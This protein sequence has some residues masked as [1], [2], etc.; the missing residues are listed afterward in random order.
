M[1]NKETLYG[2]QRTVRFGLQDYKDYSSKNDAYSNVVK[3]LM[4]N[5]EIKNKINGLLDRYVLSFD[6]E[7]WGKFT[8]QLQEKDLSELWGYLN[9]I[10][11]SLKLLKEIENKSKHQVSLNLRHLKVK[12][13]FGKDLFFLF[14][15]ES[16]TQISAQTIHD[17]E[18][19]K[20][21]KTKLAKH[22][23]F[24]KEAFNAC[25]NIFDVYVLFLKNKISS[26]ED[27]LKR[28]GKYLENSN[29]DRERLAEFHR[30]V[31]IITRDFETLHDHYVSAFKFSGLVYETVK[32]FRDAI[33][34]KEVRPEPIKQLLKQLLEDFKDPNN[35]FEIGR[36]TM[37]Y[38]TLKKQANDSSQVENLKKLLGD[39]TDNKLSKIA[40]KILDK[41]YENKLSIHNGGSLIEKTEKILQICNDVAKEEKLKTEG[42]ITLWD[43]ANCFNNKLQTY[44]QFI[45][46][47]QSFDELGL[48]QRLRF[49]LTVLVDCDVYNGKF[50][51]RCEEIKDQAEKI[52]KIFKFSEYKTYKKHTENIKYQKNAREEAKKRG[53]FFKK[54][55]LYKKTIEI[56]KIIASIKGSLIQYIKFLEDE[57]E[58]IGK[59]QFYAVLGESNGEKII[60]LADK[61][62]AGDFKKYLWSPQNQQGSDTVFLY[63]SITWKSLQKLF[64]QTYSN[65]HPF[66]TSKSSLAQQKKLNIDQ[67]KFK[68]DSLS[69]EDV[70]TL[71]KSREDIPTQENWQEL[72]PKLYEG[73]NNCKTLEKIKNCI[74]NKGIYFKKVQVDLEELQQK[75]PELIIAKI[76]NACPTLH[77]EY[78]EKTVE[79]MQTL[80]DIKQKIN[81]E[82]LISYVPE[83]T[84]IDKQSK[85][86]EEKYSSE[87]TK[88][89]PDFLEKNHRYWRKQINI[90]FLIEF[91]LKPQAKNHKDSYRVIG[92]DRGERKIATICH[93]EFNKNT[94]DNSFSEQSISLLP[95]EYYEEIKNNG[96]AKDK[97]WERKQTYFLDAANFK[98]GK[99]KIGDVEKKGIIFVKTNNNLNLKKYEYLVRLQKTLW[100]KEH[101]E[102]L[103]EILQNNNE[104]IDDQLIKQIEGFMN[105]DGLGTYR[106]NIFSD[107]TFK[108]KV[109]NL[110]L[111][112]KNFDK[113]E[114][115]QN[116]DE[117]LKWYERKLNIELNSIPLR[118]NISGNLAGIINFLYAQNS[119][120]EKRNTYTILEN[121][122]NL[123]WRSFT[124]TD[125]TTGKTILNEDF[126]ESRHN[127]L[128]GTTVYGKI[129]QALLNK[130]QVHRK[131]KNIYENYSLEG[132][133]TNQYKAIQSTL[134][135]ISKATHKEKKTDF[136]GKTVNITPAMSFGSVVFVDPSYTSRK[137]P[138]CGEYGEKKI[139][140]KGENDYLECKNCKFNSGDIQKNN[141]QNNIL[142]PLKRDFYKTVTTG[143]ENGALQIALRGIQCIHD[144]YLE[145][146][147]KTNNP[148]NPSPHNRPTNSLH[149]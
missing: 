8:G 14:N 31:R 76:K 94:G 19:N 109:K 114:I 80:K 84:E 73:L 39:K 121:L 98:I 97:K 96:D 50:K 48:K 42:D 123:D 142:V 119:N 129:Q 115:P 44:D 24:H 6:V 40:E 74:E 45:L 68:K 13:G 138:K 5:T 79:K 139:T 53:N 58:N 25:K 51:K 89:K 28:F 64:N 12:S 88:F 17:L 59:L 69:C 104:K 135:W 60:I 54:S 140:R 57:K 118:E 49:A 7:K 103:Q 38:F 56:N 27:N 120:F 78:F 35:G 26:L 23:D 22:F 83:A 108:E 30:I 15:S 110:I 62:Y 124:T 86:Q 125:K 128:S 112:W 87:K 52:L 55:S 141:P 92:I 67:L 82:F 81:P 85:R 34:G 134:K 47:K 29:H 105:I 107:E 102:K 127:R 137:C 33:T 20:R 131:D 70:K 1:Q 46:N 9:S 146:E 145:N 10:Q 66:K 106:D 133:K 77:L 72:F 144:N 148:S 3:K 91:N 37:H 75:F 100:L 113:N 21:D 4:R 11:E 116:D 122:H 65:E 16:K 61:K 71:L 147:E 117:K 101:Q 32:E 136:Y 41:L 36:A 90:A 99:Y 2:I 93:L 149:P 111:N 43:V 126:I 18:N 95:F 132:K 143:D 63:N 130:L